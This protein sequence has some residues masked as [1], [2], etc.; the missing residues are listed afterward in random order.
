M[1]YS[2]KNHKQTQMPITDSELK[3]YKCVYN[4]QK[5][6][7]KQETD[8]K[9]LVLWILF[10]N[11]FSSL[12]SVLKY[13]NTSS[14]KPPFDTLIGYK[15]VFQKE[16]EKT[17]MFNKKIDIIISLYKQSEISFLFLYHFMYN[18]GVQGRIQNRLFKD[19]ELFL[20]YFPKVKKYLE[21]EMELNSD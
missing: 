7:T 14:D 18:H 9:V 3:R 5:F 1:F 10:K 2:F 20:S 15:D 11:R 16:K 8:F 12:I 21:M 4:Y 17:Q 19:L 13:L 6:E